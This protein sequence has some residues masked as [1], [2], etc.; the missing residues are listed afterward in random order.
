MDL[1]NDSV[2]NTTVIM[3]SNSLGSSC[4]GIY[5]LSNNQNSFMWNPKKQKAKDHIRTKPDNIKNNNLDELA[6]D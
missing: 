4:I 6:K 3:G 1:H 5:V 2:A